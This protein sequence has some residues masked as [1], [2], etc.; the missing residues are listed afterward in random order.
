[1]SEGAAIERR[2]RLIVLSAPSGAGKTTLVRELLARSPDLRF[3]VSY[4]TRKPRSA[5]V[6]GLDYFFVDDEEFAAMLAQDAF[7]EHAT[8]FDHRYG[9][10]RA[11][12]EERL[13]AGHSVLLEIDWQGARQVRQRAPEALTVFILPP[14][15][16]ELERRLRGR[17][18]DT[19]ATIER[20][21][22]DALSDMAHWSEFDYVVVNEDAAKAAEELLGI[23]HGGGEHNRAD[24]PVV[25]ARAER[26]LQRP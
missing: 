15:V 8:V 26:I 24:D 4:T 1:M 12:V 13:A 22:A 23:I 6:P 25:Q 18:T 7:L 21:L 20:R 11:H 10:S 19:P 9:T 17:G 16:E 3:S 5:E 14:S 2:G